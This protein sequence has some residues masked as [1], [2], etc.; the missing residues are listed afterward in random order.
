MSEFERKRIE[1]PETELTR[2]F[3]EASRE[4]KLVL[5]WCRPCDA[6]VHYPR[7]CCPKCLASDLEWRESSGRG[8]VYAFS[9]M[10]RAANPLMKVPYVV[11]LVDLPE[12]ARLMTNI[13]GCA[14]SEVAVGM[15]VELEWEALSDGRAVPLFRPDASR[16]SRVEQEES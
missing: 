6:V 1:P 9:V 12:G 5:Q 8:E 7:E 15:P 13:V 2:P 11:A 4:G 10:H 16:R 14:P 3:W